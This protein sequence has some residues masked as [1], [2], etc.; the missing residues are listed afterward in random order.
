[1][2]RGFLIPAVAGAL[3]LRFVQT[4]SLIN[5]VVWICIY[6]GIYCASM[7]F[8]GMNEYEHGLVKSPFQKILG[9]N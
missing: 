8:L 1:M 7:W 2:L 4:S 6:T 9:R 5:L 3:I